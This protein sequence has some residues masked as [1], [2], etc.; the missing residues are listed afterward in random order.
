[1]G[2]TSHWHMFAAYNA[3]A[4]ARV[5]VAAAKL[6][7]PDYRA[8]KGAFFKSVHGTLNHLLVADLVWMHRFTGEGAMP[9]RLDEILYDSLPALHDARR[10][11]DARIVAY[12]DGL[13]DAAL[14]GTI[15]YRPIT[16]TGEI[17]QE[18]SPA[19]AHWFNHQTH[20]RGQVHALLTRLAGE[21]PSLDLVNFQRE[22]GMAGLR[23]IG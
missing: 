12:V 8:D 9:S 17:V 20:H 19:L 10:K 1:M 15:R 3:W 13:D 14:A 7:D 23:R 21:A 4:N 22:E 2:M 11:E 6:S 18:L 5:F 16:T